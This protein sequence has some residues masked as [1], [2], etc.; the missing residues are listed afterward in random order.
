MPDILVS[1]AF[2]DLIPDLVAAARAEIMP[3]YR[4]KIPIDVKTDASPVTAADRGA[5]EALRRVIETHFP[6]HGIIGEEFP[7]VRTDADYVWVL[8][9][10]DGT[11][12]FI[13]GMPLFATLIG[14]TY[15]GRPI[16]GIAD[17][18]ILQETW[19]AGADLPATLNG[20][21]ITPRTCPD[22]SSA[23]A[24][25]SGLEYW[26]LPERP[27][28]NALTEEVAMM[29][30]GADSYGFLQVAN[31]FADLAVETGVN[32]Y[33]IMALVP[34]VEQAGGRIT[35]FAGQPI[36]LSFDGSVLATG[37]PALHDQ[38]LEVL[39]HA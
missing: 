35:D 17:Q 16:L 24:F 39:K 18:A 38:V 2:T 5:E 25:T 36:D 11:K 34:I 8:D 15:K 28:L 21:E 29:R 13:T 7:D 31:G 14:L 6:D 12:S 23:V 4:V 27:K 33:D 3:R 1:S 26:P 32:A 19:V 30:M 20:V 9:P 10:I 37:D 22:L